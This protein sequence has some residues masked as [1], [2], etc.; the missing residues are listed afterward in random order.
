M[1]VPPLSPAVLRGL[2]STLWVFRA[3]LTGLRHQA[4]N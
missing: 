4:L 3:E 2:L 1:G